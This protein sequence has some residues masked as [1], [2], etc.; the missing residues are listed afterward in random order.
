MALVPTVGAC[1]VTFAPVN[2]TASYL[3]MPYL[4]WVAFASLLNYYIWKLN[5]NAKAE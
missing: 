4:A 5:K 1:V 2:R 3:M